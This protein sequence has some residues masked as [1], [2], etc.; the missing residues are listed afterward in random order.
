MSLAKLRKRF[1]TKI[2]NM[3]TRQLIL[4]ALGTSILLTASVYFHL[5]GMESSQP[6]GQ[7]NSSNVVVAVANISP[8]TEL[9][10][11][12]LKTVA[13]PTNL[14]PPGALTDL[15]D[16]LGKIAKVDILPGDALTEKKLFAENRQAGFRGAIPDDLRAIS[17]PITDTTGLSGFAKPGDAVDVILVSDKLYRNTVSSEMILQ[18][19]ILLGINKGSDDGLAGGKKDELREPLS[20]AT[21]AV[22]PEDAVRLAG[23]QSEGTIYL[24]L[25]PF[26]P[27]DGF[28]LL[29]PNLTAL[30]SMGA[31]PTAQPN[32]APAAAV[33]APPLTAPSA[34]EAQPPAYSAEPRSAAPPKPPAESIE[35][36]RGNAVSTV[37]IR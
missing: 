10:A 1:M 3:T 22:S 25:R 13:M 36:I 2:E 11:E 37:E 19:V 8:K 14:V 31:G 12:M 5:S 32:P 16:A 34:A 7:V 20:T 23:V 18:N 9:R 28:L 15:N 17:V 33:A 30:A 4:L 26:K 27:K 21:L 24:V 29:P 6:P 35:V